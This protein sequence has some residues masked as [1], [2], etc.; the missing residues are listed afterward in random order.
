MRLNIKNSGEMGRHSRTHQRQLL[1][2][3]I[4]E[5]D[6]HIDARE[7]FRRAADRDGSISPATVYRSLN[8]FQQLGLVERNQLGKAQC[9]YELKR[10]VEHQH[11]V[12]SRCGK[13][14]DFACPLK[15]LIGKVQHEQGFTVTKAEVYFEGYC[16]DC[17]E[18]EKIKRGR[19]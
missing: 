8:L 17:N 6:G 1:L 3:I 16:S 19:T 11:L 4:R 13:V 9:Y 12:C 15:D 7:L 5:V 14:I 2:D 18:K 10:S